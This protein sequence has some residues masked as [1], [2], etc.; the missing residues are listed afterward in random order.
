MC[1]WEGCSGVVRA[2]G[3]CSSHYNKQ[4]RSG[5]V[6]GGKVCSEV[7]CGRPVSARAWCATHYDS[8][9][10]VGEFGVVATCSE[11][12]CFKY[13]HALDV[14]MAHYKKLR[15]K[16]ET[17]SS[18]L[19]QVSGCGRFAV[20]ND[21]CN[22]H[23]TQTRR[24]RDLGEVRRFTPGEWGTPSRTKDGYMVVRRTVNGEQ[25][26]K[27]QHRLVMEEFLGRALKANENVHHLN[28][29]RD[30]NRI[31][32]LELWSKSQPSGQRVADKTAWAIEWLE[33]YEPHMLR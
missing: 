33:W 26:S 18:S 28:G 2:K 12:G 4:R 7:G 27:L 30:D 3:L 17:P 11:E 10:R 21:M 32:N 16:G 6:G 25:E 20:S 23:E 22:A 5:V 8:R 13:V 19:C 14:C 9:R 24:G 31:E 29:I 1:E 15:M